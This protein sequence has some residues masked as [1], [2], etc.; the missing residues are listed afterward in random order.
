[1]E[2][3]K[4]I[5]LTVLVIVL[6]RF[7]NFIPVANV[8]QSALL[9]F[10]KSSSS[11]NSFLTRDDFILSIFSLGIIPN[12]NASILIQLLISINPRLERLQ[13]E[14]GELGRTQI[15]KYI[16]VLTLVLA[17]FESLSIVFFLKPLV[18]DWSLIHCLEI[19][20][21]LTT[22]SMV[23]LWLSEVITEN[24]IGNGSS[25]IIT[26][27]ILNSIST[28]GLK[29]IQTANLQ[30]LFF[31]FITFTFLII[32]IIYVQ[33]A[34]RIVPFITAK[35]LFINRSYERKNSET[36]YIPLKI[37]QGGVMPLIFS[38]TFLTFLTVGINFLLRGNSNFNLIQKSSLFGLSLNLVNFI[39]IVIFSLFYSNLVLN[40]KEISKD[41]KKMA[42]TV[43]GVRPG[44]QTTLFFKQVL[45]RLSLLGALFLG[46]LVALPNI[47]NLTGFGIT[48]L[49]ILVGVSVDITRQIQTLIISQKY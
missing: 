25:I 12:I 32:G 40:P 9:P 20:V 38:S 49:L 6:I 27:G 19:L 24:G 46:F 23:M 1:M 37:N 10:L 2:I 36:S 21:S 13:K 7:G 41:L 15:K 34:I 18:V 22:G 4:R 5:I 42:I 16:R 26:L 11:L 48:S 35:Q 44:E 8:N 31:I 3:I 43:P 28:S 30:A 33:E 17:I 39:L 14:E 45:T 29:L 47:R